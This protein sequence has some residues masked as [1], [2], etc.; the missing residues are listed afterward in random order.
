MR[1]YR[2]IAELCE[3]ALDAHGDTHRGVGWPDAEDAELR[4]RVMLELVTELPA[5]L[6]DFGCG[7]S[8]LYDH[9]LREGVRGVEYAGLDISARFVE[10]SRRKHPGNRYWC[11]DVLTDTVELPEF[12]FVVFNGVFTEKFDMS[13]EEMFAFLRAVVERMWPHTRKGLA[14][15]VMTT[16]V[17]WRHESLFQLP[18]DDLAAWLTASVSRHFD[19]RADYGLFDYTTYVYR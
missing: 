2:Q 1:D 18:F 14:F 19:I 10:L 6:L 13:H 12:D 15:N 16:H 3:E 4:H 7:A 11:A 9:M 8:H 5:T 17:E